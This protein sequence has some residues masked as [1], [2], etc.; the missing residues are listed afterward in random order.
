MDLRCII[1]N[2]EVKLG[3]LTLL[4]K[5]CTDYGMVINQSK[6]KFFVINDSSRDVESTAVKGTVVR[7]CDRYVYSVSPFTSDGSPSAAVKTHVKLFCMVVDH[8]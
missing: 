2:L 8:G 7:Y 1:F 3:F 5:D 6:T 4:Q